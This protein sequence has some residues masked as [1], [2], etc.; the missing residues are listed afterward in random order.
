MSMKRRLLFLLALGCAAQGCAAS[1][2]EQTAA[3]RSVLTAPSRN[4]FPDVG[5]A[6]QM[7]C[8]TLD[9][10]GQVGRNMR[11]YGFGGLRL[12]AP[13]TPNGDPTTDQELNASYDSVVGLEPEALSH[14][15]THQADPDQLSLVRKMR[16]IERHKG[17]QQSRIGD[18]LD[19]CVVSWL[20]GP[21]DSTSCGSVITAP[22][23]V[24][25]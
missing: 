14:V 4:D 22:T 17:G 12:S 25:N 15:V 13:E 10:H 21:V 6:L 3:E 20:T 16:G 11:L 2:E 5:N 8:G 1:V 23:P 24:N 18:V 9:C 19:R 7:R